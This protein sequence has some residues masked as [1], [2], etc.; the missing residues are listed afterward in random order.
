M[1]SENAGPRGARAPALHA[2]RLGSG[3]A[4]VLVHGFTQTSDSWSGVARDLERDFHVVVPDL[5][6]HG[7]SAVPDPESGLQEAAEAV[8]TAGGRASYVGYSLGGRCCLQLALQAPSLVERLVLV[9]AHPGIED[10]SSRRLRRESDELLAAQLAGTGDSAVPEFVETWLAGPLFAHLSEEQADRASRL[11]NS[12]EGLSASLRTVGTG[13]QSPTW[14]RLAEL[15]M[16]V[17]VVAG[18]LDE[19]FKTLA[20]RAVSCIGHNARL[21]VVAGAGHA[22]PFERPGAF[23]A[24]LREFLGQPTEP[25]ARSLEEAH[26]AIPRAKRAPNAS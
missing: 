5:P 19:K 22:V 13:T 18:E 23:V 17:L 16:P 7:R 1:S 6:G 4:V 14:E 26:N 20:K 21:A 3:P 12:A 8:G 10:E 11:Q 9:G 15:E 25:G 2:K 24:L